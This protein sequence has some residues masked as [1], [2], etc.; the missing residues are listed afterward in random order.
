MIGMAG[1]PMCRSRSARQI[2]AAIRMIVQLQRLPDGK[3]KVTSIAEITGMEGDIIQMQEIF[4]WVR[5]RTDPDGID[6]RPPRGDG[7]ARASCTNSWP[8]G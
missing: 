3:R 5:T 7:V 6:P 2:A 4:K 8:P 1:L